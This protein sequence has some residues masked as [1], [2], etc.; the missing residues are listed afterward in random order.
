MSSNNAKPETY[1]R[2]T[3]TAV[4][5]LVALATLAVIELDR[6]GEDETR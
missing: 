4:L 1:G 3:Y 2:G 6:S 5:V